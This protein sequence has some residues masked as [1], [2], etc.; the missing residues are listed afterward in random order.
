[1]SGFARL[2]SLGDHRALLLAA[3]AVGW[4]HMAGKAQPGFLQ[5]HNYQNFRWGNGLDWAGGKDRWPAATEEFITTHAGRSGV[6]LIGLLQAAHGMASGIEKNL[7]GN[8]S[9]YLAQGSGQV[10]RSSVFG[11]PRRDLLADPPVLTDDSWD[12]LSE[13]IGRVLGG[14]KVLAGTTATDV[15][16]W[17]A[18]RKVAIGEGSQIRTALSETLAETRLP[19][20]DVTLWDQSYVA[21]ALFK[22][23]Y[24]AALLDED[25]NW[26]DA[27]TKQKTKWRLLTIGMAADHFEA[28]AVRIGDWSAAELALGN[29]FEQADRL[30]E[31][32]LALGSLLFRDSSVRVYSFPGCGDEDAVAAWGDDLRHALDG[33]AAGLNLEYPPYCAIS[34]LT[35]TLVPTT[36]EART[37]RE[38]MAVPLHRS[39]T[40][41]GEGG[42][43]HVC[44]VCLVRANTDPTDKRRLCKICL[45][46]RSHR[47]DDW[48]AGKMGSDTIW[49][50]EVADGNDR[51]ALIT[52]SLDL[53][54]WLNGERL[55]GLRTQAIAEWWEKNRVNGLDCDTYAKLIAY[56]ELALGKELKQGDQVMRRVQEGFQFERRWER[57]F[58]KI[59]ED[60]AEAPKWGELDNSKRAAWFVHQLFRKLPSP[61]RVYRFWREAEEFFEGLIAKF[62]GFAVGADGW[63]TRRLRIT[64]EARGAWK[65]GEVYSCTL[66]NKRIELLYR[67]CTQDFLTVWNLP[68]LGADVGALPGR[69]LKCRDANGSQLGFRVA[70]TTDAQG[71]LAAYDP[72]IPLEVSPLRCRVLV[73]LEAAS[74]CVDRAIAAWDDQFARVWDRLPLRVGVVAFPR[75]LPFQAVIGATRNIEDA[76]AEGEAERW[77]VTGRHE[78]DGEFNLT[79]TAKDNR[80]ERRVIPLQMGSDRR[81]VFYPYLELEGGAVRDQFDF[82]HPDGRVYR[83]VGDLVAGDEIR[84]HPARFAATFL[85]G[86]DRRF[87]PV[88]PLPL[89]SWQAMS[90]TWKLVK[91]TAPGTTAVR[92]AWMELSARRQD[93]E[94]L[95]GKLGPAAEAAWLAL[96]RSV[97]ATR[98]GANGANLGRLV[99]A[100]RTGA[101]SRSLAW[102]L[103]VLKQTFEQE[104]T[105]A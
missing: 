8:A 29:F 60:R 11:R 100:A 103:S 46:R 16:P 94:S 90:D 56:M 78:I 70:G 74:S 57:Y 71:G 82:A 23:A 13:E 5:T 102:H 38:A 33:F 96:V 85:D 66:G 34:G 18:W 54:P 72:V 68:R 14:L 40:I 26:N 69:E 12:R 89:S 35:R 50:S 67:E 6:G 19:N 7:P 80:A 36:G 39:W 105:N 37:A 51:L 76:L 48:L 20:N 95:D 93:W 55:D 21:A 44:P 42:A 87:E 101:L 73:P 22:S 1:M 97:L 92:R 65:D 61:G 63:R 59:V 32:D 49:I 86:A 81:D 52:M 17:H 53:E 3:E 84:V 30:I 64:P 58:Q 41:G 27:E 77:R 25:F 31:V 45:E 75:M 104:V 24:A 88:E 47:R 15:A 4:F 43:G 10:W 62:R 98:W 28:R 83:H 9:Q 99:E 79:F 2:A 91:A